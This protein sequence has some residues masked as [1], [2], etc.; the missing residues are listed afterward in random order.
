[1]SAYAEVDHV[2]AA[3][4]KSTSSTLFTEWADAP[5]RYFHIPGDPPF[6]CFQIVVFP[7]GEG[8][9]TVQAASIDTNDEAEMMQVWEGPVGSLNEMLA[10]AVDTVE[11][12][13]ARERNSPD[14]PSP[15]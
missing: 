1:M 3:W 11:R 10:V 15:W 7:P 5:S 8:N 12:W 13:K 2:I 9:V 14:P 4:V 6:E